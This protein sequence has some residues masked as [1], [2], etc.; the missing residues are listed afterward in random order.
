MK[1]RAALIVALSLGVTSVADA[2]TPRVQQIPNGATFS[3]TTCHTASFPTG[4]QNGE[5]NVFGQQVE[6]NLTGGGDISAQKV[7]WQAIY[8]LDADGDGFTN[9]EELGDPNGEWAEGDDA[10]ADYEPSNPADANDTPEIGGEDAGGSEDAGGPGSDAGGSD[11][12]GM[13]AD[14]GSADTGGTDNGGSTDDGGSDEGCSAT[15]T[16]DP[17]STGAL[18]ALFGLG[19]AALRRRFS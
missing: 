12:A 18:V 4:P 5:R 17:L 7:D 2:R 6:Q 10:P 14:T 1:Y 3:C 11:D 13:T 8:D 15:G 19:L 16:S 9:G